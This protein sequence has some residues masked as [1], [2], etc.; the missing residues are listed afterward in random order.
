VDS[1]PSLNMTRKSSAVASG[2]DGLTVIALHTG[3]RHLSGPSWYMRGRISRPT[4]QKPQ[5][6]RVSWLGVDTLS[7]LLRTGTGRDAT[8]IREVCDL[9]VA[10]KAHEAGGVQGR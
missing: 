3:H 5:I 10:V 6:G 4:M 2:S 9:C 8:C 7:I 1:A